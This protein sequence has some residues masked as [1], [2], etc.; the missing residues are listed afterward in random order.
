MTRLITNKLHLETM[1]GGS[2]LI[3]Q[4]LKRVYF[5]LQD[6]IVMVQMSIHSFSFCQMLEQLSILFLQFL[7]SR[8]LI[9]W[10]KSGRLRLFGRCRKYVNFRRSCRNLGRR[11][12]NVFVRKNWCD[13]FRFD[14]FIRL[15]LLCRNFFK[16]FVGALMVGRQ[17]NKIQS[18]WRFYIG[19]ATHN[20]GDSSKGFLL[21]SIISSPLYRNRRKILMKLILQF[22][23]FRNDRCWS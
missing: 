10:L 6:I 13:K 9:I 20:L 14:L 5:F 8:G 3:D 16:F 23:W 19:L 4:S 2:P 22:L 7:N 11:N 18:T 1:I 21:E 15:R 12:N 17:L